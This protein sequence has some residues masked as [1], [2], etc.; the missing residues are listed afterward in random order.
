MPARRY[1]CAG[2][3]RGFARADVVPP[4]GAR[5]PPGVPWRCRACHV[6]HLRAVFADSL[7]RQLARREDERRYRANHPRDD[8][9]GGI[10]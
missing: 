6:K 9:V 4:V 7:A 8:D 1:R 5:R 10:L 2:C 3:G